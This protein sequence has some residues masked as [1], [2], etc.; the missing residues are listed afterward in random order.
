MKALAKRVFNKQLR[1]F[2]KNV[3]EQ[4][5]RNL[6]LSKGGDYHPDDVFIAGFPKCGNTWMQT[7]IAGMVYGMDASVA[8]IRMVLDLV[9]EVHKSYYRRYTT[10]TY[11]KTHLL[12][13]PDYRR[14]INIVRDGRDAMLSYYHYLYGIEQ[15][16][17]W[18][19]L[20]AQ[21]TNYY[22]LWHEHVAQW[23]DNPYDAQI[24]LIRYEDLLAQPLPTLAKLR[25]FLH[26][27]IDETRLQT[28]I[29]QTT[30]SNLQANE[31]EQGMDDDKWSD[32]HA[33]FRS[34]KMGGYRTLPPDIIERLNQQME[35][36]LLR[37]G[38]SLD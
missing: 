24:I 16:S 38:Y 6:K 22:G 36:M 10:P 1:Q 32:E 14:V 17:D 35:P 13:Q 11:F 12:P 7:I 15:P 31:A 21:G 20:L 4:F 3:T 28:V 30:F 33:F 2:N 27:E 29:K 25:D 5:A 19:T 9:P 23:L 34:G 18:E 26:L 37:L 8:P